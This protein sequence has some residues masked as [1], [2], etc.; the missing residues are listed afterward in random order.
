M[1]ALLSQPLAAALSTANLR[2]EYLT[3][4][5]GIDSVKPRLSWVVE[6]KDRGEAQ[7]AYRILVASSADALAGDRGDLWDSGKVESAATGQIHYEGSA[8]ES[9]M[10]C[11]WKVRSW[12]KDGSPSEW[13]QPASWTV[14]LLKASDWSAKWID[15]A[16]RAPRQT[17]QGTIKI[18]SATYR[19]ADNAGSFDATRLVR[20]LE[21]TGS[22]QLN[23]GN[24]AMGADPAYGHPKE[25]RMI[26]EVDGKKT[27]RTFPEKT[28]VRFPDDFLPPPAIVRAS[29]ESADGGSSADVTESLAK[30]AADGYFEIPV[31]N[32]TMGS[33]PAP[34]VVKRLQ[35]EFQ[36]NGKAETRTIA[37]NAKF[38]FPDDLLKAGTVPYLRRG[39]SVNKPLARA[40]IHATALG[41][42]ELRLNGRRVGDHILAPE[43]TDYNK[44]LLYQEYDVTGLVKEGANA[45]G[46]QV[47]NGWYSGHIGNGGFQYWGTS[48]ALFAQLELVYQ[49]GSRERVVTDSVWKSHASPLLSTD[50]MMGENYDATKEIPG[51]DMP[52]FDDS[53]WV[54]VMERAEPSREFDGQ[55]MEP[56]RE[57]MELKTKTLTEPQPGKW[58]YDLAQ[59]MV[60]VVRLH[61]QAPAGT[62]ITLRHGEMLNPDG[63]LYT[64]NL[65]GAPSIDTYVCKG[66]GMETWQP[67][68]TFHGFRYV[69]LTGVPVKPPLDAV[70]GI[71]IGSDTPKAG[72]FSCSDPRINQ[73]QSNI[74]WGQRGN[75]LS[76]PTD[77]PQRDERLGWMG[78]AQVFVGTAIYNSDVAPFFTKWLV[79]VTDS[80]GPDGSFADVSPFAGPSTGTPAWGDAGVIC[81]WT[82]YETYGDRQLLERQYPSMTA[83]LDWCGKNSNNFVR[84]GNRGND[85]GDWLSIGADTDKEL[86]GTAYYAYSASLVAKAAAALGKSADAE[87]YTKLFDSIKNAFIA[88]YVSPDGAI[89]GNTQTAWL[90]ALKFNLLPDD[91]RAIAADLL[92]RDII[93]KDYHLSTGFV[94]VSYLLPE[95]SKAGKTDTAYRLLM[96]DTFPSWLFSVKMGATTIWERWDGWTPDKGFQDVGMNSFNHYSLGSCGE[97]L[98]RNVGGI[99]ADP[100]E[101]GFKKIV[102]HPLVGGGLT[103]AK[104]TYRSIH[105]LIGSDWKTSDGAFALNIEIPANT[106][107][108]VFV[109]AR[110]AAS[111]RESGKSAAEAEGVTFLRTENGAAVFAVGSGS[112]R[113]TAR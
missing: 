16:E 97:W 108:T 2:C 47:A 70:T 67:K 54:G 79:D 14:G 39:F 50:F 21:R 64:A 96:Q 61:I 73:L 112:Y 28:D 42:Y 26:Y 91:L 106:T 48:P 87:A 110:N 105:G 59:N 82:I 51:W 81:P 31:N 24:I 76:V 33:D 40:T 25:L 55:V 45:L 7:T 56:V 38:K 37:E 49:D 92:E 78:D 1:M 46:A 58:T 30:L 53:A 93:A 13:S 43:W 35:V 36:L 71:V 62:R 102:I 66:G 98:Y 75:Y 34:D 20:K 11:Y 74:E 57:L 4:P 44:R 77:C 9:G 90:L 18:L 52:G 80:Q 3:D 63:T 12:N 88:K 27:S 15:A 95:V 86:L 72:S 5:R 111:V 8:L 22:F 103:G 89:K 32:A 113:F 23:V 94:G 65:R 6:S 29:Y 60:G 100:A 104:A 41:I 83:W 85:Y 69:E 19:A 84:S 10:Q 109:P 99:G 101:P 17:R 107:A 68:F